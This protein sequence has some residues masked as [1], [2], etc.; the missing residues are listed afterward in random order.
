ME[1]ASEMIIIAKINNLRL[2]E[3]PTKLRRDL[4]NEKSHLRT[5]RD[6]FRHLKLICKLAIYREKYIVK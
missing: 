2:L 3:V 1:Y 5:I 4:R 6:G